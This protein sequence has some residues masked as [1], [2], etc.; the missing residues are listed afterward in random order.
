MCVAH[1]TARK[2]LAPCM[3]QAP[4]AGWHL[5]PASIISLPEPRND[6]A[7]ASFKCPRTTCGSSR[8]FPI[9]PKPATG[10]QSSGCVR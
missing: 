8:T 6:R 7:R 10:N 4:G 5:P 2:S 3:T 9:R 1:D